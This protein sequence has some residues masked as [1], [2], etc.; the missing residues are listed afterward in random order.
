MQVPMQQLHQSAIHV[1][2]DRLVFE[3]LGALKLPSQVSS[4]MLPK[5]GGNNDILL[6]VSLHFW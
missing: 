6:H 3:R 5:F 4:E 2:L 1:I